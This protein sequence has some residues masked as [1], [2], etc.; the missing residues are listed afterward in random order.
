[1]AETRKGLSCFQNNILIGTLR[2]RVLLP[3]VSFFI[4]AMRGVYTNTEQTYRELTS[5]YTVISC[6][7]VR[8]QTELRFALRFQA[9]MNHYGTKLLDDTTL[10]ADSSL[11]LP[12][13]PVTA[14]VE[15]FHVI[16]VGF[17]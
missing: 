6:W 1:M 14:G 9:L 2:V 10:V 15:C 11:K 7:D 3:L 17:V 12:V 16:S 5:C 13:S 4:I 8:K